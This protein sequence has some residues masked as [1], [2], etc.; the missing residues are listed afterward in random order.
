[1]PELR[2]CLPIGKW[3]N[4][5]YYVLSCEADWHVVQRSGL[6]KLLAVGT[7][8]PAVAAMCSA[9]PVGVGKPLEAAC[10]SRRDRHMSVV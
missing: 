5:Y 8:L 2:T 6:R 3:N 9:F 10:L 4:G 7:W 1:L